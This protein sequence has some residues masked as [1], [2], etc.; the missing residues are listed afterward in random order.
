M[1]SGSFLDTRLA[2]KLDERVSMSGRRRYM[3]FLISIRL[4][5][6]VNVNFVK[7]VKLKRNLR[8]KVVAHEYREDQVQCKRGGSADECDDL[9]KGDDGDYLNFLEKPRSFTS[10]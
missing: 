1:E 7:V 6:I 4:T 10:P 2:G 3:R 9:R 8:K 5:S